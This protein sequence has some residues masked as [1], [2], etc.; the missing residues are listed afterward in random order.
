MGTQPAQEFT[1]TL[2]E[3]EIFG[4]RADKEAEF[5]NYAR[6]GFLNDENILDELRDDYKSL[7]G[8]EVLEMS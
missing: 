6:V 5:Y 4:R 7:D 2:G 3:W 8:G 1:F